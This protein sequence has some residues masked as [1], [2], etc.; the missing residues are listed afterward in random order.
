MSKGLVS[1]A[2]VIHSCPA[3]QLDL[4]NSKLAEQNLN[5]D[6]SP[7]ALVLGTVRSEIRFRTTADQLDQIASNL[8]QIGGIHFE[9]VQHTKQSGVTYMCVPGLGLF[10]GELNGSGS[11]CLTEDKLQ[12]LLDQ[13]A[14]N[15]R[16]FTRLL[17]LALGQSWDDILEPFRASKYEDNVVLLNRAG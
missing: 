17:R 10:R 16:E 6:W 4:V 3:A 1:T 2:L 7:Q 11:L 13:A 15:Y 12:N 9:L 5:A 8:W 14:G